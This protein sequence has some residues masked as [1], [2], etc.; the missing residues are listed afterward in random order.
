MTEANA[1]SLTQEGAQKLSTHFRVREFAC[2]D[3]SDPLFISPQLVQLLEQVRTHFNAP[4][5]VN[6]GYRTPAYNHSIPHA[7]PH[8]QHLYGRAA[9]I[10]VCGHAPAQVAA[11]AETLLP[12]Q[13]WHR[14]LP[15]L[16]PF[17]RIHRKTPLEGVSLAWRAS[18]PPSLP[19]PSP[20]L[21]C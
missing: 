8:S 13:R 19:V 17:G 4:V 15:E 3:G 11:Y 18:F 2:K 5:V 20:W 9:D 10:R 21:A 6:S 12:P 7:S 1:Y 14:P 16:R